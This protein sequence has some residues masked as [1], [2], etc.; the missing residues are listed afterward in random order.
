MARRK[1]RRGLVLGGGG[2]LGAAWSVGALSGLEQEHGLDAREFDVIVGTSAGSVLGSLLAAG[3]SVAQLAEHQEGRPISEGPLA[4]YA[5]DYES[6]TGGPRPTRPRLRGPGSLRL[7]ASSLR[8]GLRM[9]PTAMLSAF[10]PVGTGSLDRVGHLIDAVTPMEEWSP[11]GDL[12]IVALDYD[13]GRRVVFG[14]AGSPAVPLSRAV[15]ASCAIPGWF[16]PVEIDGRTYIDGGAW[17]ATSVDVV[18]NAG[19]DEVIVIAP[20]VSFELDA[21]EGVLSRLERRWRSQ[22]TRRCLDEV[23]EV[24]ANGARVVLVGPGR[25]DLEAMGGNIMDGRRRRN[26]LETSMRTSREAFARGGSAGLAETG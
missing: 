25:E 26:V 9:P 19:L 21:P 5:W 7:M 4:G 14:R 20:M 3:V 8:S 23:A 13:S 16:E 24:E 6:A 17:S 11:H 22:V 2:V 1:R 10:L 18:A 15:M 12:W